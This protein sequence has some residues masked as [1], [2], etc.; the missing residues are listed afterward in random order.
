MRLLIASLALALSVFLLTPEAPAVA[1]GCGIPP[2]PPTPQ[3]GCR[4]MRPVCVCDARGSCR[5]E[6]ECVR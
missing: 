6:F 4:T 1:Q 2:I 5:W 3:I